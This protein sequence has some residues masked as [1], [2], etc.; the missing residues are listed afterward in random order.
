M[1]LVEFDGRRPKVDPSVFLAPDSWIIGDVTL[2]EGAGVWTGSI[3][4]GDDDRVVIGARSMVLENSFIEAPAGSPVEVGEETIISHGAILH[5]SRIG[6]RVL[7]GIGAIVLDGAVVG[8]GSI[9]GSG[10][11]V[12]P[13]SMIP[14]GKLVL[15]VPGKPVRDVGEAE[16]GMVSA[17]LER[18]I[19]KSERYRAIYS[20]IR[21]A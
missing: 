2:G 19:R 12:P 17:E 21:G 10:A 9:V 15:G 18:L 20:R 14:E 3:I 5:G 16:R 13:G 7:I 6:S 1:S 4:R 11:L 8:D